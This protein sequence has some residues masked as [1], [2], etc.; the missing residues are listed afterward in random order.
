ML[1]RRHLARSGRRPWSRASCLARPLGVRRRLFTRDNIDQKVEHVRLGKGRRNVRTLQS[2]ALVVLSMDP[3][4]HGQFGDED[5]AAL[6]EQN[7]CLRGDHLDLRVRFHHL[8]DTSERQLMYLVVMVIRFQMIDDMLPIGRQDI[9]CRPLE[10]LVY[11]RRVNGETMDMDALR[12]YIG[13]GTGVQLSDWRIALRRE[14]MKFT[15]G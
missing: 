11:L 2:A 6:G 7:R 4:A 12:T 1:G 8:L 5:V 9:A 15:P 13:P 14:L 10:A 3:R